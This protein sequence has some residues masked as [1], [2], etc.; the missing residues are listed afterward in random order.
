MTPPKTV[1]EL[2]TGTLDDRP[3][4][5]VNLLD[6]LGKVH[7]TLELL[8]AARADLPQ[9][10]TPYIDHTEGLFMVAWAHLT[11]SLVLVD[12]AVPFIPEDP[13]PLAE[14]VALA[15]ESLSAGLDFL[16]RAA[17]GGDLL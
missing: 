17:A 2:L 10:D 11:V 4:L 16:A 5:R 6:M 8:T 7:H 9:D 13:D 12:A 3:A 15:A 14:R 1:H